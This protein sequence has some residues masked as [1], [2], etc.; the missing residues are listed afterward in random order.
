MAYPF[1]NGHSYDAVHNDD[2]PLARSQRTLYSP[3]PSYADNPSSPSV[4]RSHPA[5]H[6]DSAF[7]RLRSQRTGDYDD[8]Y[9]SPVSPISAAPIPPPHSQRR[10]PAAQDPGYNYSRPSRTASTVTP[11]RDN[12]GPAAAGGGIAGIAVGVAHSKERQSGLDAMRGGQDGMAQDHYYNGP[13]ERGGDGNYISENPYVSAPPEMTAAGPSRSLHAHDAY[14]SNTAL[15]SAMDGPGQITPGQ[16]SLHSN[17]GYQQSTAYGGAGGFYDDPYIRPHNSL[18]PVNA[19]HINPND[20]IDDGDDGFIRPQRRSMLSLGKNSS[21]NS[22]PAGTAA[23]AAAGAGAVGAGAAVGG[24]LGNLSGRVQGQAAGAGDGGP[25]Y[26]AVPAEKSEWLANQRQ[27]NKKLKWIVGIIIALV[28]VG[29]IVGG[30]VGGILGSKKGDDS[31][32][33]GGKSAGEDEDE[34]G[35]LGKNSGE[36]KKLM[37]MKG[38]HK[39]FPGMDYTP[40]GTQYPLCHEFPPSQ[41]N[42]T[43]DLAVLSKLTNTVRLYGTDCNQTEM[44][45]HAIDRLELKDMKVWL[46]VWIDNNVTTNDRQIKQLYDIVD[47]TKDR[48]VFK[49]VIVGNE[50][51]YRGKNSGSSVTS[52]TSLSKYMQ[53][54]KDKLKGMGAE[55]PVATSDLGDNWTAELARVADAVMANVHPFFA[56][57]TVAE[58]AG[59]TWSFWQNQNVPLT[60]GTDKPQIISE[61]GWPNGGGNNCSPSPCKD[62]TSGSI[63]GVDE[64]NRFMDDW[65][66][67]ALANGTDYFWFE[68]FDEPWKVQY[69]EPELGKEWEDKW[70]LMDPG[71]NLKPGLKIP[72]CGG[73]TAA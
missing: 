58:A 29:A 64:L 69:N 39:V 47:K 56:G 10:A 68:A 63:A 67:Q 25:A 60:K 40:W 62:E 28:L 21:H 15:G 6:P 35:D 5:A 61:V 34:N 73:K 71:R 53:D 31:G 12:L 2:E 4:A 20:I 41:N 19:E 65:V 3:P 32:G 72:D 33:G 51:L 16:R 44:V 1:R 38:L 50:V 70:G 59:W 52:I 26:N 11:G 7:H 22:L 24:V 8:I 14:S 9:T 66:C 36:I 55:M 45:L 49:G 42:V 17:N 57:V 48:S 30:T 27:G 13:S 18:G 46:G 23:G 54:V 43:R 37:A